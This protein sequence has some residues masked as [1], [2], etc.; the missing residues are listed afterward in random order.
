VSKQRA[1]QKNAALMGKKGRKRHGVVDTMG[2]LLAIK[3]HAANMHDTVSDGD[4]FKSALEKC[5]Q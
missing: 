4:V 1:R 2:N 5:P 3:V